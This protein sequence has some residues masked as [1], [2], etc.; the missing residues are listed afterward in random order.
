[1]TLRYLFLTRAHVMQYEYPT[2]NQDINGM[3]LQ[4]KYSL[5]LERKHK[6]FQERQRS[7]ALIF[8]N[9]HTHTYTHV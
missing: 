3:T 7:R 8:L 1:M 2:Q 6:L 4:E 9:T 5:S